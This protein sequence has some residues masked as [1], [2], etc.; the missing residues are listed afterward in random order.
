[1][2]SIPESLGYAFIVAV[3]N[4]EKMTV[5]Q[6]KPSTD[7]KAALPSSEDA[8]PPEP[9]MTEAAFLV[10][11]DPQGHWVADENINRP[12]TMQ[13]R[14]TLNDF[15]LAGATI[16]KDVAAAETATRVVMTQQQLAKEMAKQMEAQKMMQGLDLS[17]LRH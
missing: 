16:Q 5:N 10:Y 2:L 3:T 14:P 4:K 13:R 15:F 7:A 17:K 8:A 1:M 9:I 12:V 6:P 11:L